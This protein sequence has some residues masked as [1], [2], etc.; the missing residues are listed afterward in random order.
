MRQGVVEELRR[1]TATLESVSQAGGAPTD[2]DLATRHTVFNNLDRLEYLL[3]GQAGEM[4]HEEFLEMERLFTGHV[5]EVVS[6]TR[7]LVR[8]SADMA[9]DSLATLEARCR[10]WEAALCSSTDYV[11]FPKFQELSEQAA[12]DFRA[13]KLKGGGFGS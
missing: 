8:I 9:A 11:N 7:E 10:E 1:D 2:E 13:G 4:T 5:R 3:Y 6:S 12:R